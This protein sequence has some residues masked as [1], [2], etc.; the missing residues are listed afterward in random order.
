MPEPRNY[1]IHYPFALLLILIT[2]PLFSQHW[3]QWRGA[4]RDGIVTG[5]S[6]P[7]QWP[8]QLDTV[9]RI[10][11]GAGLASPVVAGDRVYLHTR[12]GEDEVVTCY[13]LV[14]GSRLWQQRYPAPF[15]PNP[16]ATN[17]RLFPASQGKGPFATPVIHEGSLYTLGVDRMLCS[18]DAETGTLNW[19]HQ[20]MQQAQPAKMVYEC[21]PCGCQTDGKEF[22][23]P[24]TCPDCGMDY[25]LKGI[26]TSASLGGN[27]NYYGTAASPLID[28]D[29]LFINIGNLDGGLVL[30][31]DRHTGSEK[32]R[33]QGP[34]P[35]SSS[36]VVATIHG[37]RQLVVLSRTALIGLASR[38]GQE[39]WRFPIASNAQIVTPIIAGD[40]VIFSAYRSPTTAVRVRK[41]REAWQAEQAWSTN[42]VTLYTSTPV[43][44]DG[45]V[46]G[47]SYANRGQFFAMDA[48]TGATRWTSEGRIAQGA[49]VLAAGSTLFAL[50]NEAKLIIIERST[51]S[52]HPLAQYTVAESPTWAHPVIWDKSILVKDETHL[53]RWRLP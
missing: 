29:L 6:A 34:P 25:G 37:E 46:Y 23:G 20:E 7:A 28:G 15:L 41:N 35:S 26:E 43:L 10:E 39:L 27:G 11:T 38:D 40:L 16:Q 17:P 8:A 33:W 42:E 32:W 53:T 50:T 30:A 9:W 21:P 44:V 45:Q 4:G 36:P 18:F 48:Q 51:K 19:R 49:A 52:Y 24:G 2:T 47:L 1:L 14:D 12:D 3:P 5:F 22:S 31:F 13:R